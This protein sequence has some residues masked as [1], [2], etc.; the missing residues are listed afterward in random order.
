[1]RGR[2]VAEIRLA[3]VAPRLARARDEWVAEW[4]RASRER[5]LMRERLLAAEWAVAH[6]ELHLARSLTR[7]AGY[8]AERR[9]KLRDAE[10]R[11]ARLREQARALGIEDGVGSPASSTVRGGDP[12]TNRVRPK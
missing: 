4:F 10:R 6:R 11:L 9:R 7:P 3:D 5:R 2:P 1:M 12:T 8:V